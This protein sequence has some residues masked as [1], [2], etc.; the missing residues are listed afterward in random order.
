MDIPTEESINLWRFADA[1]LKGAAAKHQKAHKHQKACP[2]AKK[3]D[4]AVG[5]E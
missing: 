3:H 2:H 4:E 5:E 1:E